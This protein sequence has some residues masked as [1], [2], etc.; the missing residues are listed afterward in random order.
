MRTRWPQAVTTRSV[1][2]HRPKAR[3]VGHYDRL[4][5]GETTASHRNHGDCSSSETSVSTPVR[6]RRPVDTSMGFTPL[7]GLV[8]CTRR[9]DLDAGVL[10]HLLRPRLRRRGARGPARASLRASGSRRGARLPRAAGL[11][12]TSGTGPRPVRRSTSTATG[13][14]ST[15]APMSRCSAARTRWCS[16]AG[17][18]EHVAR[19]REDALRG[20][21]CS[22]ARW[23]EEG[24]TRASTEGGAR[25]IGQRRVP[26]G[27]S[28]LV[29]PTDEELAIAR[30][31]RALVE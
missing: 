18:G 1:M 12:S 31:V 9:G 5:V 15:S 6:A 28:V 22:A 8:I 25:R 3:S 26:R 23:S 7:E 16:P 2:E 11:Q 19:V 29:V 10:L 30:Q 13:S 4:V 20:L 14:G 27:S 24:A 17:V 21:G